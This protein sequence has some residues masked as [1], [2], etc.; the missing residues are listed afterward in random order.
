[1]RAGRSATFEENTEALRGSL[2]QPHA[3][4]RNVGETRPRRLR[5]FRDD[6]ALGSAGMAVGVVGRGGGGFWGEL[7]VC[8]YLFL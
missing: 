7:Q 3:W 5:H 8:L 1:M 6:C 2:R 4:L